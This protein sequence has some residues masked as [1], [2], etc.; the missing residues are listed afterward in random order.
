MR[1]IKTKINTLMVNISLPFKIG[2]CVYIIWFFLS[3][4]NHPSFLSPLSIYTNNYIYIY[5]LIIIYRRKHNIRLLLYC[6]VFFLL[7]TH[8]NCFFVHL[9]NSDIQPSS[10][11]VLRT[12]LTIHSF[13]ET[14]LPLLLLCFCSTH[15]SIF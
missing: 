2:P 5:I 7:F 12:L 10:P 9:E 14:H 6:M 15:P 11:V 3:A 4:Q 1:E 8:K 13:L